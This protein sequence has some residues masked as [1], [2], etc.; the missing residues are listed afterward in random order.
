MTMLPYMDWVS[1]GVYPVTGWDRPEHL[2]GPG[3][4]LDRLHKW[5]EGKS[6]LQIIESGDQLLSMPLKISLQ[7]MEAGAGAEPA[8]A[9]V[10]TEET[11]AA[12]GSFP[13][14]TLASDAQLTALGRVSGPRGRRSLSLQVMDKQGNA[15]QKIDVP[16]DF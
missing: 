1:N 5:T 3:R 2:D 15:V 4:A 14:F 12:I 10:L 11:R 8:L 13:Q 7:P 16:G 9:K 6:Q